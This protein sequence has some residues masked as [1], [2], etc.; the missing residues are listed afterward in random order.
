[1]KMVNVFTVALNQHLLMNVMIAVQYAEIEVG[2]AVLE[3]VNAM[4]MMNQNL[5][6]FSSM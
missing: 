1:M 5:I 3:N 4:S 2:I 6:L